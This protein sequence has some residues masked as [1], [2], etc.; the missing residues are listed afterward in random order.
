MPVPPIERPATAVL[1][2]NDP[3]DWIE[4]APGGRE[5]LPDELVIRELVRLDTGDAEQ[6]R[7]FIEISGEVYDEYGTRSGA[8]VE[9]V[10]RQL[11]EVQRLAR[12]HLAVRRGEPSDLTDEQ[13]ADEL[14]GLLQIFAVRV[15]VV[16]LD[17]S[18]D[19]VRVE[20]ETAHLDLPTAL[21][22]QLYNIFISDDP[23]RKCPLCGD[24]FTR[25][26]GRAK[27]GQYRVEGGVKFCSRSC[28]QAQANRDYRKR[29]KGKNR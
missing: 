13:F 6:L 20:H 4:Y 12:H 23:L 29:N 14:N 15:Q 26:R 2:L 24:W 25:Q 22:L 18:G 16:E 27:Q 1:H 3:Y 17:E 8:A 11:Q 10:A 5:E 19:V 9:S 7:A 21:A 28:A